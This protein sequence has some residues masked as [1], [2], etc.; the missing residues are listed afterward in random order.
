VVLVRSHDRGQHWALVSTV[1][2]GDVGTEGYGEPVVERV[3]DGP[4][5]GRFL[6][7]IRTG[8]NVYETW[9][10]DEGKTW[11]NPRPRIFGG[12]DVERT[13]LWVD[14]FRHIPGRSGKLLDENNPDE[15]KGAVVDPDL[16]TLPGGLLVAAFGVRV[17]QKACWPH[18]EH[19]WNGNYLAVSSDGGETWPNVVRLTSGIPTTHYMAI[20]RMPGQNRVFVAYDYGYWGHEPR[21]IYGR[22]VAL[23]VKGR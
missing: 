21:Y 13:E 6:V 11:A 12:L 17:P 20:E 5:A 22:T 7:L 2:N 19:P 4:H 1:A 14:M 10:D 8:R 15:L 9:S 23:T 16:L 18:A 3:G